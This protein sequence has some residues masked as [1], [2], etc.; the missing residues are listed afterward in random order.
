MR[1]ALLS[2]EPI[3][4]DA[5]ALA[6]NPEA[7][8]VSDKNATEIRGWC[9]WTSGSINTAQMLLESFYTSRWYTL[10]PRRVTRLA[11]Y[12]Y[13]APAVAIG[14]AVNQAARTVAGP[15][16]IAEQEAARRTKEELDRR[17]EGGFDLT[18][19]GGLAVGLGAGLLGVWFLRRKK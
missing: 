2:L 15:E 10:S 5:I 16:Y 9:Q 1:Q 12:Y 11:A 7:N 13:H 18:S 4:P 3:W 14:E 19:I 17:R 8:G 6:E